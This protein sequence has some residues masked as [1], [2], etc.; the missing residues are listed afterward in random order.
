MDRLDERGGIV[1]GLR[2]VGQVLTHVDAH[3]NPARGRLVQNPGGADD[4]TL[5][6]TDLVET[7]SHRGEKVELAVELLPR[8]TATTAAIDPD[9]LRF[10]GSEHFVDGNAEALR[11]R[12][13]QGDFK[14]AD[15]MAGRTLHRPVV[16]E[17]AQI[18]DPAHDVEAVLALDIGCAEFDDRPEYQRR[19][20]REI[21]LPQ[22]GDP[23]LEGDFDHSHRALRP[24]REALL[25]LGVVGVR[26]GRA[27]QNAPDVCNCAH[28]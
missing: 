27:E 15:Y 3:G 28:Q 18:P 4:V 24:V 25:D 20:D 10:R 13:L 5:D 21:P 1:H 11:L 17:A 8:I 14:C 7:D 2:R 16:A 19:E 6:R 23:V 26:V 12:V 22:P 9:G